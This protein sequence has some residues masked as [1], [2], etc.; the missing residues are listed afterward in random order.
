MHTRG[1]TA[2][3]RIERGLQVRF[4]FGVERRR[5]FVENQNF[6]IFD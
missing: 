6:R 4:G 5:R 2:R 1:A 3:R